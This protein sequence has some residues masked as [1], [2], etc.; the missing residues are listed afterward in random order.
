MKGAAEVKSGRTEEL[1]QSF[2]DAMCALASGVMATTWVDCR[3]WRPT[4]SAC[5]SISSDPSMIFASLTRRTQSRRAMI[6]TGV[7]GI[8]FLSADH[9]LLPE[10][11]PRYRTARFIDDFYEPGIE[12]LGEPLG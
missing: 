8:N 5:S 9:K 7:F 11:G 12:L 1:T 3:S 4:A 6:D 10:L 2:R